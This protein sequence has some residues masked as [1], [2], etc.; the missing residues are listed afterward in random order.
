M[1]KSIEPTS[2]KSSNC[3]VCGQETNG[4]RHYGAAVCRACAAFFRRARCSRLKKVCKKKNTCSYSKY[5]YFPCK[6]C[7][8]QKCLAIGMSSESF[9][10]NR[11]GY[12]NEG[13]IQKITP[14]MDTF[15]GRPNFIIFQSSKPSS[16][17]QTS[18]SF[19]DL[20]FLIDKATLLFQQGCE[21]PIRAK[22]NLEKMSIGL[23]KI[24][25][26]IQLPDPQK[27]EKF[28]RE[29][30]LCQ[31]EYYIVS[32]TKWLTHFDD[33]QALSQRLQLKILE[34]IWSIWWK[35][36]RL[37]CFV[38]I[39]RNMITEEKL[40]GMKQDQLIYA[41]DQRKLDMSWLCNKYTV[42]ELKFFM[43][44]PTEIRLDVLTRSMFELQPSDMELTFM[45]CQL[46]FHHV[47]K[48]FQGK[49]LQISEKFQEK[50]SN[51]LH[52]YY[53]NDQK[54]PYYMKRLASM[55]KINNQLQLDACRNQTKLDLAT[56]FDIF[57]IEVSHPELFVEA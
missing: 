13:V 24:Q 31:M 50:L 32:V 11:D 30:A 29:E 48:R 49:I 16:N 10:F 14:T 39:V 22:T 17:S 23:R 20:Q 46:C 18:K 47:G 53:V 35:L 40:R 36:E 5:G 33:F 45:L 12:Q 15:C 28:G 56:V 2:S 44:I 51:D 34:G 25:K 52:D 9:Q 1:T 55:M 21:T 42:E 8:L 19:L 3:L 27:I 6:S 57:C 54:N 38:R 37:A 4:K 26:S 41:W 43:D 7:R